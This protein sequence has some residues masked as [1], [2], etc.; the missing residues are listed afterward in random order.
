[1]YNI[2]MS[3][4]DDRTTFAALYPTDAVSHYINVDSRF[5]VNPNTT[6][7]TDFSLRLPRTYKN[8]VSIRLASI[9]L[10]NMWYEFSEERSNLSFQVTVGTT[11]QIIT[12]PEG[13]YL[14][15][16]LLLDAV[17]N[18]L[19]A[20]FPAITWTFAITTTTTRFQATLTAKLGAADQIFSMDF[21]TILPGQNVSVRSRPFDNGIGY[22]LGFT[23]GIYSGSASY[24][25]ETVPFI[26]GPNYVFMELDKYEG[27][28]SVSF[29]DSSRAAFAKIIVTGEKG[30][31]VVDN[32]ANRISKTVKFSQPQN[33]SGFKVRLIDGYGLTL[34]MASNF[35]FTLELVE[36][37][38]VNLYNA[39]RQR[40]PL[41]P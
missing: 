35:S 23:Q 36:A 25:G 32:E 14:T 27:I 22:F 18:S 29:S 17:K 5:R 20:A 2:K 11:T 31:L 3:R 15:F 4:Y 28:E 41:Q 30:L 9:E 13:N 24:T 8:V 37:L 10:P 39:Y 1:M 16:A 12:I 19:T 34:K 7:S 6:P 33:V 38:N 21:S 40:I 26:V